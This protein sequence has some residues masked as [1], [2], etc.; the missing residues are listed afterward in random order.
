[1]ALIA[2]HL[3]AS[4][5]MVVTV[6]IVI[7]IKPPSPP[8]S[9]PPPLPVPH[10]PYGFCGRYAPCLLTYYLAASSLLES[11]SPCLLPPNV[12]DCRAAEKTE[13]VIELSWGGAG[14]WRED[15]EKGGGGGMDEER[16]VGVG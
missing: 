6:Y 5:I 12:A 8:T 10:K 3:N 13:Q 7:S 4:V 2:A 9:I 15:V 11:L 16:R 14:H 1:M